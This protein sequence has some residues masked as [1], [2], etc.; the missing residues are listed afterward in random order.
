M[1][2]LKILD[3]QSF[4]MP[5]VVEIDA[6]NLCYFKYDSA[7]PEI[8]VRNRSQLKH[9]QL[10]S[11]RPSG[12]LFYARTSLPSIA[13]NVESLILVGCGE[14][15]KYA[16]TH[17]PVVGDDDE[18]L[19]RELDFSHNCLRHVTITGFCSAKCLVELTVHILES[20]HSLER[21]TLDTTYDY[22]QGPRTI[23]KCTISSKT[24]QCWPM[25]K[26]VIDEAH[27]AVKTVDR[28]IAGRV[29][30]AVQF[31]LLEPCSRCHT[32]SQ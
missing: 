3:V 4:N 19:R 6:P 5:R 15:S 30:L 18:C 27:R 2:H 21:L 20:T 8:Y 32:G 28:Y 26:V 13:R 22:N 16:M 9:V 17:Y 29:P 1:H 24:A 11:A 23:G 10:S 31:E 25:S 12:V 7:L 14:V